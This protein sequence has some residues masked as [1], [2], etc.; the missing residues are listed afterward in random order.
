MVNE[1]LSRKD[2]AKIKKIIKQEIEKQE[3]KLQKNFRK[4][5]EEAIEEISLE[6]LQKLFNMFY[7]ERKTWQNKVKK[8]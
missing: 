1:D 6:T 3:K 8:F 7:K 2:I 4:E 5:N